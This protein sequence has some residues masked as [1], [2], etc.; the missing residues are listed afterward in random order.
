MFANQF[1]NVRMLVDTKQGATVVPRRPRSAARR[2]PS[3]MRWT[4]TTK[5]VSVRKRAPRP[6]AGRTR[7]P[8]EEGIAARHAGGGG[9]RRQAARGRGGRN[10]GARQLAA[11]EGRAPQAGRQSGGEKGSGGD[12]AGRCRR[13]AREGGFE[14][15]SP[16][17]RAKRWQ[18]TNARIDK[19]EF[20]EEMKKLPEDERKQ[21][22]REL[23]AESSSS[24]PPQ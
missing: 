5:V 15:L 10:G 3:S 17:E 24:K 7:S 14:K 12:K 19:G 1:V 4:R 23:R 2:A 20:G 21:K 9:R 16:E 13:Q 8:I 22:M 11:E 6:G 18:E